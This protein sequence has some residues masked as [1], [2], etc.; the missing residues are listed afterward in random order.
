MMNHEI[1]QIAAYKKIWKDSKSI[2]EDCICT[3]QKWWLEEYCVMI[4]LS[5]EK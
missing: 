3:R 2:T 5:Q 1:I 4:I